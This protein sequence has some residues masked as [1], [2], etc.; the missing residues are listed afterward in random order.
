[1]WDFNNNKRQIW[2]ANMAIGAV[3]F[4]TA[5]F[6]KAIV[7]F[8]HAVDT[9]T[10]PVT[11]T[12]ESACA[13]ETAS[14]NLNLGELSRAGVLQFPVVLRCNA[15]FSYKMVSLNGGL[16][17]QNPETARVIAGSQAFESFVPYTLSANIPTDVGTIADT[18]T[19]SAIKTGADNCAF[20]HSGTGVALPSTAQFELVWQELDTQLLSGSYTDQ[21]TITFA[22]RP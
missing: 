13:V 22:V 7:P 14:A 21:L 12:V 20:T 3:V 4:G 2:C 9:I 5:V 16:S 17:L 8:A 15:P 6:S 1:M 18:C 19:S 10:I 11:G